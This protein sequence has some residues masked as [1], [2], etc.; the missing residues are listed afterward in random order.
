MRIII[1]KN[2]KVVVK[3][4]DK[5]CAALLAECRLF[6]NVGVDG[7]LDFLLPAADQKPPPVVY[8][9]EAVREFCLIIFSKQHQKPEIRN[10]KC[11]ISSSFFPMWWR[12]RLLRARSCNGLRRR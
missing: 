3:S 12:T 8:L 1:G 4:T 6:N 10:F 11:Q 5:R 9:C 7:K 2:G